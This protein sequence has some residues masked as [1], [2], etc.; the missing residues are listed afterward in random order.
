[1]T[2][3]HFMEDEDGRVTTLVKDDLC[4]FNV[5]HH[6]YPTAFSI[7]RRGRLIIGGV[8]IRWGRHFEG[9]KAQKSNNTSLQPGGLKDSKTALI[10]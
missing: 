9:Q 8:V 1:M 10:R 7:L 5:H 6:R 2:L 4:H 3:Q